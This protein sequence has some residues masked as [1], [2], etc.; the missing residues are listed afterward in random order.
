MA[1]AS[2]SKVLE[3]IGRFVFVFQ[4]SQL[5]YTIRVALGSTLSLPN[6]PIFHAVTAS[7]DFRS[8]CQVA[9]TSETQ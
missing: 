8:L 1:D 4:F 7:Y 2:D 6:G 9:T 3:A 5:E